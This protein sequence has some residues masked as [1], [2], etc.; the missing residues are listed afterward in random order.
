VGQVNISATPCGLRLESSL[1]SNDYHWRNKSL[2]GH[3]VSQRFQAEPLPSGGAM[4]LHRILLIAMLVCA[5]SC[6]GQLVFAQQNTQPEQSIAKTTG[7]EVGSDTQPTQEAI[8]HR[9]YG[10]VF[11]KR[12]KGELLADVYQPEGNGPFPGVLMIHGGGWMSGSRLNMLLHANALAKAGYVVVNIEYRLAPAHKFPAQLEDCL[13]AFRWMCSQAGELHINR[14]QLALYGYSAGAHLACLV[15]LHFPDDPG[16]PRPKAIVAGGTPADF[17]W[18]SDDSAALTYFLGGS[19]R[20]LPD[21]YRDASPITY[22]SEDDPAVFLFHGERDS[23]VPLASA[24]RLYEK[25]KDNHVK[26]ELVTL[27]GQGHI[28]TFFDPQG[29]QRAIRFLDSI[30]RRKVDE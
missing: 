8:V 21:V 3:G 5:S 9:I 2:R 18:I 7:R 14:D 26:T 16:L 12:D 13:D 19:R 23:I 20:Q 28:A 4:S 1:L 30:F 10:K 29:P 17:E 22:V 24:Q 25:L 15:G 27:P 11:A 6:A